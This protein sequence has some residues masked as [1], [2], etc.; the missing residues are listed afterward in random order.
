MSNNECSE[1][2]QPSRQNE[3][4]MI[5]LAWKVKELSELNEIGRNLFGSTKA[6]VTKVHRQDVLPE[7]T[8]LA[9][10]Q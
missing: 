10:L 9:R 1:K 4:E 6:L 3:T 8:Y 5:T 2:L 7:E